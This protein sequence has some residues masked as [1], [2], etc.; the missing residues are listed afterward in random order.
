MIPLNAD[1][2]AVKDARNSWDGKNERK[3]KFY[4]LFS[5]CPLLLVHFQNRKFII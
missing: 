1:F 4:K 5:P 2:V 3:R